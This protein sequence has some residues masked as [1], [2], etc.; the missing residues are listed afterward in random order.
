MHHRYDDVMSVL[1][2]ETSNSK[3]A[4]VATWHLLDVAA[5]IE[6]AKQEGRM[7]IVCDG[8]PTSVPEGADLVLTTKRAVAETMS[9][10][11]YVPSYVFQMTEYGLPPSALLRSTKAE[12]VRAKAFCVFAYSN[13][14][15]DFEGVRRRKELYEVLQR[16]SG[17]RVENI[18]HCY[19]SDVKGAHPHNHKTFSSYKFVIS[20]ESVRHRGY[21]SEKMSNALIA[22]SV[23]I[24]WGAEDVDEH[25]NPQR[26]VNAASFLSM[27]ECAAYVLHLDKN[28]DLY[29]RIL[30]EPV[31]TPEQYARL[32]CTFSYQTGGALHNKI[33]ADLRK[34][35]ARLLDH[36]KASAVSDRRIFFT[37]DKKTDRKRFQ[38]AKVS[39]YFTDYL[40]VD[41]ALTTPAAIVTA[42]R[43]TSP[44]DVVVWIGQKVELKLH[45]A[46][47][48]IDLYQ[49]LDKNDVLAYTPSADRSYCRDS[50]ILILKHSPSAWDFLNAWEPTLDTPRSEEANLS[51]VTSFVLS[52]RS[53]FVVR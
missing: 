45:R 47:S 5:S 15:E 18:G 32:P 24:Y 10:A 52:E 19:N 35:N 30:Q 26:F 44:N 31:F 25:F 21:V 16:L 11:Y 9:H 13:C 34:S 40:E 20:F 1:N 14:C 38:T 12:D 28:D 27:E 46:A 33:H 3:I 17:E 42:L 23:P 4:V 7:V 37:A 43:S 6:K 50:S 8:E 41:P 53:A 36:L 2:L 29:S 51:R 22:G 48:M 49:A 39:A